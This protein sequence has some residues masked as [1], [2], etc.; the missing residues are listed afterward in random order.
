VELLPHSDEIFAALPEDRRKTIQE[1]T[2]E[3]E[4][5]RAFIGWSDFALK[6]HT[7]TSGNSWCVAPPD[8]VVQ[9]VHDHWHERKPGKG[10]EGLDR[11]IV[12]PLPPYCHCWFYSP[13]VELTPD[14]PVRAKITQRQDGEDFYVETYVRPSECKNLLRYLP[15]KS[16]SIVLYAADV[17]LENG[18]KRSTDCDWEIVCLLVSDQEN[19]LMTPLTMSR[20]Y[21][22]KPGGTFTNYSAK[23]FAEAIYYH[24]TKRGIRAMED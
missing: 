4:I 19:E 13:F 23:E 7:P 17:L 18:G 22:E 8:L 12:V 2:K 5:S 16:V 14:L 10:E 20:N 15:I 1:R 3:L 6:Q 9:F 11:K 21:L 24:S